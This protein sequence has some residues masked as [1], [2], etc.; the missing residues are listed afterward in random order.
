MEIKE[1]L[2]KI[3]ESDRVFGEMFYEVFFDHCPEAKP[4]FAETDM[5]RQALVLTMVL[6]LVEQHYN[7]D[8]T[9]VD[10]YLQHIG[11][12]HADRGIA[13]YLYTPWRDAILKTL[14]QFHGDEWSTHLAEQWG[15]AI[16]TVTETM[17]RGYEERKGV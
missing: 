17:F 4:Y 2:K 1:S 7:N 9:A 15:D 12:R 10:E 6:T 13:K 14:E 16:E 5:D 11:T 3:L 8:F